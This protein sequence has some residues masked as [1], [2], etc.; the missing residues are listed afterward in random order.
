MITLLLLALMQAS[1]EPPARCDFA[2]PPRWPSFC[3]QQMDDEAIK[4]LT[5]TRNGV[6]VFVIP[7]GAIVLGWLG[8]QVP[9]TGFHHWVYTREDKSISS[10][11]LHGDALGRLYADV[12][13]WVATHPKRQPD[14]SVP[15]TRVSR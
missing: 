15:R 3:F 12:I 4:Q 6:P 11:V 7:E 13:E 8:T 14:E 2:N 5:M 10:Y 9:G 1:V